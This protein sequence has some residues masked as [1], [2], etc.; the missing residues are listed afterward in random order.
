MK[1]QEEFNNYVEKFK[2][3]TLKK[4]KEITIKE[5]KKVVGFISLLKEKFNIPEEILYNR[6]I[7]DTNTKKISEEDF[8]EAAFVYT[9]II[10]E[11]F[12]EYV[13]KTIK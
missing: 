3:L 7:L 13:D 9:Y 8:V 12:A 1:E 5:M 11:A 2:K 10:R 4:K 6:E